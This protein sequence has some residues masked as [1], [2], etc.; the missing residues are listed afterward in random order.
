ME[1]G[2]F[3]NTI[4]VKLY[5]EN[6]IPKIMVTPNNELHS[7]NKPPLTQSLLSL[8]FL[9]IW[10]PCNKFHSADT[11][12]DATLYSNEVFGSIIVIYLSFI[13]PYKVIFADYLLF[14]KAHSFIDRENKDFCLSS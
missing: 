3:A 6:N 8:P 12:S 4:E 9:N 13:I 14:F 2:S 5:Y 10:D 7:M 1:C 11:H